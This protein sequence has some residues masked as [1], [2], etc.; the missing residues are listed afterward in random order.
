M[1]TLTVTYID[2]LQNYMEHLFGHRVSEHGVRYLLK[3]MGFSRKIMQRV[4]ERQ[5]VALPTGFCVLFACCCACIL[6]GDDMS[7]IATAA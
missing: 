4:F 3:R 5:C 2:E 1:I 7:T 6:A